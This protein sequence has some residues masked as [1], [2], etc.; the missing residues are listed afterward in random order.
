MKEGIVGSEGYKKTLDGY[1][2]LTVLT[3]MIDRQS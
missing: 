2:M 1:S 3:L